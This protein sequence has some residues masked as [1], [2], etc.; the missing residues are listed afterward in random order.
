[1]NA[2]NNENEWLNMLILKTFYAPHYSKV[3]MK[4]SLQPTGIWDIQVIT[5][6][7]ILDDVITYS[8]P[9]YLLGAQWSFQS[10]GT[11]KSYLTH[12]STLNTGMLSTY[13]AQMITTICTKM[14]HTWTIQSMQHP[15]TPGK[16]SKPNCPYKSNDWAK[17]P[18]ECL[19]L[20]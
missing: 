11:C 8:Y 16:M 12:F 3:Y 9:R 20:P 18:N 5:S 17:R 13:I 14:M 15:P 7:S 6:H 4:T 10:D 1:M 19:G 2:K